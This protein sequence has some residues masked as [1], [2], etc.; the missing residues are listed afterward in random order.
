M[1]KNQNR[2]LDLIKG[3]IATCAFSGAIFVLGSTRDADNDNK[4]I[5]KESTNVVLTD[6]VNVA[7]RTDVAEVA[8]VDRKADSSAVVP[9][10]LTFVSTAPASEVVNLSA[11]E[12]RRLKADLYGA[13]E[14]S[15]R[16]P[17]R[18]TPSLAR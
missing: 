5:R 15:E 10:A 7:P 11:D 8:N 18:K 2:A 9:G 17:S 16:N 6:V 14:N 1:Q 3:A 4:A 13:P 12:F